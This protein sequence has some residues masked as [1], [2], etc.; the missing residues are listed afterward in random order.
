MDLIRG[1]RSAD[2]AKIL[3]AKPYDE[4]IHRDNLALF[5]DVATPR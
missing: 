3:G 1:H 4:A 2:I 5:E